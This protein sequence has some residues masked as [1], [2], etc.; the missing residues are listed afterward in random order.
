[1]PMRSWLNALDG[2][3]SQFDKGDPE[4]PTKDELDAAFADPDMLER[5]GVRH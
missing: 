1:M 4:P 5:L 2:W 3:Q